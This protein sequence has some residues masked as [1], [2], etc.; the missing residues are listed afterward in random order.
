M[1]NLRRNNAAFD[2][3]ILCGLIHIDPTSNPIGGV[4][5]QPPEDAETQ[6]RRGGG[7]WPTLFHFLEFVRIAS[8]TRLKRSSKN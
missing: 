6:P 5:G 3:S 1:D 4:K 7:V 2:M 8:K